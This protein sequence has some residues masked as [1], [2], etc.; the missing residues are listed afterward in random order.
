MSDDIEPRVWAMTRASTSKQVDSPAVQMDV[1]GRAC[2]SLSLGEPQWLHEPLG[3]SGRSKKFAQ[4]PQGC[5]IMRTLRRGDALIVTD[6]ERLGRNFID[7]YTSIQQL[8]DRGVRII[9]LKGWGGQALDLK[10]AT[11]R[12]ML[13]IL[14]WV[15][16]VEAERVSERTRA[17]LQ[18]RR[19]HGLSTGKSIFTYIQAFNQEGQE[20]PRGEYNK[21]RGDYKR[22]LPDKLWLDQLCTLLA[23]QKIGIR[24]NAL[25]DHC[26]A[27]E[28][29]DRRGKQWWNSDV[30][31]NPK[32]I[33]YRNAIQTL[34]KKVRRMAVLGRLPEDYNDRVLAI[35]GDTQAV[36]EKKFERKARLPAA[37]IKGRTDWTL[38]DWQNNFATGYEPPERAPVTLPIPQ[39]TR[40]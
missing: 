31:I 14:A 16:D 26:E 33:P 17:G 4:R 3:T 22:N 30:R 25:Y 24:G 10:K 7:Q 34:L 39:P 15:A 13:A 29:V 21:L 19:D 1:I 18:Y 35:T 38:E 12:I 8:F 2:A 6:I 5:F 20:I 40:S 32:G 37:S 27:N 36:L 11:D 23:M 28:Y 9:I